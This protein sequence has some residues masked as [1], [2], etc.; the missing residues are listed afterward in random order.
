MYGLTQQP[1]KTWLVTLF[2]LP[3]PLYSL[4]LGVDVYTCTC[5][6]ILGNMA[7]ELKLTNVGFLLSHPTHSPPSPPHIHTYTLVKIMS[8]ATAY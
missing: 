2:G 8:R 3:Y 1:G 5:R 7:C 4:C 6:C